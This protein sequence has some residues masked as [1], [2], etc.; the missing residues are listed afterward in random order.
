MAQLKSTHILGNLAVDG[1]IVASNIIKND[2]T[3]E[4]LLLAGGEVIN[5]SVFA[6]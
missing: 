2:G 1:N 5:K 3:N 4:Q 6:T